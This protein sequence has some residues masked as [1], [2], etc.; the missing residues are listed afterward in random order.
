[1][2]QICV[3]ETVREGFHRGFEMVVVADGVAS[4]DA[5]LHAGTLRNLAAKFARVEP[6]AAVLAVLGD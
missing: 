4:F 1:V 3:E 5:V 6:A 2:T